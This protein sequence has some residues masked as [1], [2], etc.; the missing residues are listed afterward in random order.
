MTN[1]QNNQSPDELSVAAFEV[2]ENSLGAVLADAI[3]TAKGLADNL[4]GQKL[5]WEL[6]AL[7]ARRQNAPAQVVTTAELEEDRAR[8]NR[9]QAAGLATILAAVK[10]ELAAGRV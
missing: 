3:D 9:A 5:E 10:K 4:H 2:Q 1:D 7:I 8:Q 6:A